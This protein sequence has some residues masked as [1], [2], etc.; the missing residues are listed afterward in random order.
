[1]NGCWIYAGH[2]NSNGYG[3]VF[4]NG[5]RMYAHRVMYN[6]FKPIKKGQ[7]LDH[8]CR[9]RQ[10]INPEHLEPVSRRVN[11]LR[12]NGVAA[13]RARQTQCVN[14]HPFNAVDNRGHRRCNTCNRNWIKQYRSK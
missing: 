14:G 5:K 9:N 6:L 2:I 13:Q 12:G 10:C 11:I 1:M 4:G 3:L 7:Q 8:L